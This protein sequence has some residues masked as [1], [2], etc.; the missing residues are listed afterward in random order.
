MN[1]DQLEELIARRSDAVKRCN[2]N[3]EA[4]STPEQRALWRDEARTAAR[5]VALLVALR[6]PETVAR[7]ER[8]RGLS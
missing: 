5:D 1:P 3:S 8:E 4:S 7:M 2:A 6:S